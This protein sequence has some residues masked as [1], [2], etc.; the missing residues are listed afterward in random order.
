M[1]Y[2]E[3]TTKAMKLLS[4][5]EKVLFVGQSVI[6]PGPIDIAE[7]LEKIPEEKKIELPIMEDA[8]LGMCIGLSLEGYIPVCIYPRMDF[9]IIAMNQLV[10]HLDKID[11]MSLGRF[12]PK[13][14][15]RTVVGAKNP[16][17]PR[18]Q[19][20]QDHTEMLR[21]CLTNVD[22]VRLE[23]AEDIVS[24]YEKALNSERSTILIELAKE[25][26]K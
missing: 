5:N 16:L 4:W 8:Q 23:K 20:C 17:N 19:H 3:E 13:V 24:S 11:E 7:S 14:I 21:A 15:I 25:I 2:K 12:K 9:L 22:I 6:Y 10:N 1:N 26:R 18:P